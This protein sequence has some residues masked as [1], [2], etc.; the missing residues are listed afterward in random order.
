MILTSDVMAVNWGVGRGRR[1]EDDRPVYA[2]HTMPNIKSTEEMNGGP[3]AE[4][5]PVYANHTMPTAKTISEKIQNKNKLNEQ[6]AKEKEKQRKEEIKDKE[7][8]EKEIKEKELKE[9]EQREKEK[10]LLKERRVS[11][12]KDY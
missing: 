1:R 10:E 9:K 7:K 12:F 3:E 4:D 6:D 11:T 2:N 5:K 8:K